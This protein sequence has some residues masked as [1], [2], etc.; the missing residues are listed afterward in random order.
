MQF[1]GSDNF[2][3]IAHGA[4]EYKAEGLANGEEVQTSGMMVER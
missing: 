4:C 1:G 3:N 2:L